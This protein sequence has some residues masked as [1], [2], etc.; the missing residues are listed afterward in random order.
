M[1]IHKQPT[2]FL[3]VPMFYTCI[4]IYTYIV[5]KYFSAHKHIHNSTYIKNMYMQK[6]M[7]R[8]INLQAHIFILLLLVVIHFYT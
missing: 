4:N 5:Y 2:Y 7:N 6:D 1:Y 3:H 8:N